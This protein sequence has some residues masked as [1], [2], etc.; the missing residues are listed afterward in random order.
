MFLP[1][2]QLGFDSAKP[3]KFFGLTQLRRLNPLS[4]WAESPPASGREVPRASKVKFWQKNGQ[5]YIMPG[6]DSAQPDKF[7]DLTQLSRLNPLS[8]WAESPPAS[9]R[10]VP[11]ASKV[12]FWQKNGQTYIMSGFDSAQP[13]KFF[14]LTQLSRL[15]PLSHWAESPPASGREVPR[16]SKVN[17]WQKNGQTY[18]MPGFDSA[19]P[20][21]DWQTELIKI[22]DVPRA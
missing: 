8:H 18:I 15:N 12:K 14:D 13:D 5:T 16:A 7:F 11:R 17:F 10:E 19:Q 3:D 2:T 9:G 1:Q 21:K 22:T 4:H 20:D 6:F